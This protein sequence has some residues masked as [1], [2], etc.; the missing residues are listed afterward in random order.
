VDMVLVKML[1]VTVLQD[2]LVHHAHAK[3]A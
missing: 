1:N 3:L 2:S